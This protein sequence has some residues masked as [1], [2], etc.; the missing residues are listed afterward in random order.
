[1]KS[2]AVF[3]IQS[4]CCA[5]A[6]N[7]PLRV[8]LIEGCSG[9]TFISKFACRLLE[10]HNI[11][12]LGQGELLKQQYATKLMPKAT[13]TVAAIRMMAAHAKA[14]GN[15]SYVIKAQLYRLKPDVI[16]ALKREGAIIVN[17]GR[18]NILDRAVCEV[19]DCMHENGRRMGWPVF[20][21]G[22][23][24]KLCYVRRRSRSRTW[25]WFDMEQLTPGLN[26]ELQQGRQQKAF[27]MK[28]FPSSPNITVASEDLAAFQY[29]ADGHLVSLQAWTRVL[30]EWRVQVNRAAIERLLISMEGSRPPPVPHA[31]VIYN[32]AV[33]E[34]AL[35]ASQFAPLLRSRNSQGEYG[36][37]PR[38]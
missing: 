34:E 29:G 1:M 3:C 28:N 30:S 10:L 25:A 5:S 14:H 11:T 21:N 6:A 22:T 9:S 8:H 24:S 27:L 35:R 13:T 32:I 38:P 23:R 7:V 4:I 15:A 37:H 17:M 16:R 33:L 20:E 12:C 19:R 31:E 36:G 2:G 18:A 26:A